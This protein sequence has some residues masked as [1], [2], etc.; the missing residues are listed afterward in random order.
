MPKTQI[1]KHGWLK[2]KGN[3]TSGNTVPCNLYVKTWALWSSIMVWTVL[4]PLS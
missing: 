4:Y 2:L 1:F 3:L